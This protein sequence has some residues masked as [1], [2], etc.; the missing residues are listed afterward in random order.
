MFNFSNIYHNNHTRHALDIHSRHLHHLYHHHHHQ[1]HHHHFHHHQHDHGDHAGRQLHR[2]EGR[3]HGRVHDERRIRRLNVPEVHTVRP[4]IMMMMMMI[5][6]IIIWLWDSRMV[7]I[8]MRIHGWWW[9]KKWSLCWHLFFIRY[10][11]TIL[12]YTGSDVEVF[13]NF[14]LRLKI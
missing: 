13:D 1:H 8:K 3:W 9:W 11:D 14:Y 4:K 6:I 7:M 12:D 5:I 10:G 2:S